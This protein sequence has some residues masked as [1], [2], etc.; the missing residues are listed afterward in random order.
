MKRLMIM[1][2]CVSVMLLF[3]GCGEEAA[4]PEQAQGNASGMMV[5]NPWSNWNSLAEAEAATGFPFGLPETVDGYTADVFRTMSGTLL[6]I[7]YHSG[8]SEICIRKQQGEGQDISGD[9]NVYANSEESQQNG[10]TITVDSNE[11]GEV[12]RQLISFNGYSWSVVASDGIPAE[13]AQEFL[14]L[15]LGL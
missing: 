6:E 3:A 5:A 12:V 15:I 1:L 8:E 10:G 13:V 9:Y 14:D 2:L 7:R 11:A 4:E